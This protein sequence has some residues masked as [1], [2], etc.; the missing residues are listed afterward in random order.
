M[1]VMLLLKAAGSADFVS[2]EIFPFLE[3]LMIYN[4]L[5]NAGTSQ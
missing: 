4:D 3:G 1:L 5:H 2:C